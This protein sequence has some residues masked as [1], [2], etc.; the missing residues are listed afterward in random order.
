MRFLL[1][2]VIAAALIALSWNKSFKQ[3]ASEA[4]IIGP[5][6]VAPAERPV[7]SAQPVVAPSKPPTPPQ[8]FT[9]H[10]YYTDEQ[11]KRYWVDAQ[12]RRHYER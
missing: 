6:L 10:F 9:G 2:L 5:R 12:G 4:P 7:R 3:W 8:S 1:E 11:G